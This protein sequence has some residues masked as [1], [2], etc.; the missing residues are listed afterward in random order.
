MRSRQIWRNFISVQV[1][2]VLMTLTIY[3]W[4]DGGY[5]PLSDE[6]VATMLEGLTDEEAM[7][8]YNGPYLVADLV[9]AVPED[10]P[11]E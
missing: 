7:A 10:E 2:R 5:H 4:T 9:Q 6:V 11:V 8:K 3:A 1:D